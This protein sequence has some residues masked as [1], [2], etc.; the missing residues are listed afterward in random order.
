MGHITMEISEELQTVYSATVEKQDGE[1]YLLVPAR[2]VEI[3]TLEA[4]ETVR[5]A[6]LPTASSP[7]PTDDAP[8]TQEPTAE[9]DEP[10]EP[11]VSEGETREVE[12]E[13]I[14]TSQNILG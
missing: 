2:E 11:P 7:M 3:G 14:S 9:S 8:S 5:V 4:E 6:L 1:Y 12:I 10:T 13:S